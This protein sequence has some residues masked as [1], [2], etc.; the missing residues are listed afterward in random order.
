MSQNKHYNNTFNTAYKLHK[1][2]DLKKAELLYLN[3]LKKHPE[4]GDTLHMLGTLYGQVNRFEESEKSLRKAIRISEKNIYYQNSLAHLFSLKGDFD[5][6][7]KCFIFLVKKNPEFPL[8]FFNLAKLYKQKEDYENAEKFFIKTIGLV[9]NHLAAWN[10]LGN[11]Y[12][13]NK[14]Y[15]EALE[16]FEKAVSIN[17][18]SAP[19]HNNIGGI[20]K[21]NNQLEEAAESYK[22]AIKLN[23]E[24]DIAYTNLGSVFIELN[25]FDSAEEI[26]RK[27][28]EINNKNSESFFTLAG[29]CLRQERVEEAVELLKEAI[30]IKPHYDEAYYVLGNCCQARADFSMAEKCY[31]RSLKLNPE[32]PQALF[33]YG[34]L[35]DAMNRH[36]NALDYFK[37]T[38]AL[39]P[40][41][42]TQVLHHIMYLN[43][44]LGIWGNYSDE[45]SDLIKRTKVYTCEGEIAFD[46]P[47]LSLNYLPLPNELHL[48]I[49][50]MKANQIS[51]SVKNIKEACSFTYSKSNNNKLRIGYVSPDFRKHAVGILINDMFRHHD[52]EK[53]EIFAYSLTSVDD[54]L[55]RKIRSDVD[56]YRDI[57]LMAPKDAATLINSDKIH[58]LIDLAGYTTHSRPSIFSIQPAP[59]QA[60]IIG[61]PNTT[62]GNAIQYLLADKHLMGEDL[63]PFFTEKVVYLPYAF[64]S[65]PM[66][67]SQKQITRKD[68]G[69]PEDAFVFCCFNASYKIGPDTFNAW[70]EILKNVPDSVLWLSESNSVF[71]KRL[72]EA[73]EKRQIA[74]SRLIFAK[75]DP[76]PEYLARIGLADLF[77]D[78]FIYS[79]GSTAVCSLYAG[80]PLLTRSGTTNASRMGAS[81]VAA[82]KL[83]T[84]ICYS[85]KEFIEKAVYY[86]KNTEELNNIKQTL[87]N[88]KKSLPLFD[89]GLFVK[90]L[91]AAFQM[92]WE[93]YLKGLSPKSFGI[94]D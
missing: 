63:E 71:R 20:H 79:A 2:G 72:K 43:L 70:A 87:L 32:S 23:P 19:T 42:E 84:L 29:L 90:N 50:K 22:R 91:E 74:P 16:C 48:K 45:L 47:S 81:I 68:Y 7:E 51:K 66:E 46:L 8:P 88:D 52:R 93:R 38:L 21:L 83:E 49:S 94:E 44:K 17:S 77:L 54:E 67:I 31:Q 28:I 53:F 26:I 5:L 40:D 69:L 86:A 25:Q 41:F 60:G 55:N 34:C 24:F 14:K 9:P 1:S 58:I 64:L 62:G 57:S 75:K 61:Y 89:T 4:H 30:R 65:S 92:M 76:D 3:I 59:V 13:L 33:N 12:Q 36:E 73:F 27:S 11:I 85:D 15:T 35:L 78:T 82:A 6:A 56:Y 37:K 18:E 39:K 80:T 10:N